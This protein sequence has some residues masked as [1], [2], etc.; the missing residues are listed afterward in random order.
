M[1]R[2]STTTAEASKVKIAFRKRKVT[3]YG[4]FVLIQRRGSAYADG[5][6]PD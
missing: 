1:R 5:K 4:G 3:V 2:N 6:K